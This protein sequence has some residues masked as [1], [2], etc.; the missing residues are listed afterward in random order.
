MDKGRLLPFPDPQAGLDDRLDGDDELAALVRRALVPVD[1]ASSARDVSAAVR[2]RLAAASM[3]AAVARR[4]TPASWY[5]VAATFAAG[6]LL[7]VH[8]TA[9]SAPEGASL[10]SARRAPSIEDVSF[11]KVPGGVEVVWADPGAHDA[12]S[13][14]YQVRKCTNLAQRVPAPGDEGC[15]NPTRVRGGRWLDT[16]PD[17]GPVVFYVIEPVG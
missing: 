17:P 13:G 4:E 8:L 1:A 7:A 2:G 11:R 16:T 5:A 6:A 10:P 15:G 9:P 12:R 3:P 14:E